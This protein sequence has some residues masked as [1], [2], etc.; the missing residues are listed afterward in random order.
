M[1]IFGE[2]RSLNIS[3]NKGEVKLPVNSVNIL[4]DGI[5]NDAHRG[6]GHRQVSM[7]S[8]TDIKEVIKIIPEIKSGDFAENITVEGVDF[9]ALSIGDS[10][11]IISKESFDNIINSERKDTDIK[12]SEGVKLEVTQIGKECHT[13]CSIFHKMGYCIMP[14]SGIFCKVIKG[15]KIFTGDKIGI[16]KK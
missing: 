14:K 9:A 7:L 5:E 2:I 15:G 11:E 1:T 10:I 13:P 6:N 4:S 16:I 8:C 12:Y 3:K